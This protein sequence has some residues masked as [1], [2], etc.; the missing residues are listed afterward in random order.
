MFVQMLEFFANVLYV[1][2]SSTLVCICVM[3]MSVM[4][5]MSVWCDMWHWSATLFVW[6]LRLHRIRHTIRASLTC[7]ILTWSVLGLYSCFFWS[8]STLLLAL[9]T[10]Q[11]LFQNVDITC[12]L[13]HRFDTLPF[14][15]VSDAQPGNNIPN[16]HLLFN[17]VQ[18]ILRN[19]IYYWLKFL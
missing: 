18:L 11:K 19:N 9:W 15:S 17:F 7:R 13:V 4:W 14:R 5:Y 3:L 2:A 1:Y 6:N 16:Y 10:D 8:R 12:F